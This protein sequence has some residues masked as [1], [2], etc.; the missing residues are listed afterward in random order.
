M[1]EKLAD[2]ISAEGFLSSVN[3]TERSQLSNKQL[4]EQK[5]LQMVQ[6]AL[7]KPKPRRATKVPFG[8]IRARIEDKKRTSEKKTTRRKPTLGGA[9]ESEE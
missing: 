6:K 7:V 5:L 1:L 8:V 4:A 2:Q 3:Q 9:S